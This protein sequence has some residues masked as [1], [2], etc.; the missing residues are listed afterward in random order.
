MLQTSGYLDVAKRSELPRVASEQR[1]SSPLETNIK[2]PHTG[3]ARPTLASVTLAPWSAEPPTTRADHSN[4]STAEKEAALSA[5][6]RRWDALEP[7]QVRTFTV[8]GRTGVYELQE[9]IFLMCEES[10]E[11]EKP[12]TV[13]LIP[14]PSVEDPD[15]E[16]PIL[17]SK[18][19]KVD[20]PIADLTMDPTQD[21]IVVSEYEPRPVRSMTPPPCN[22]YHLLSMSTG[23]PHPLAAVPFLDFPPASVPTLWPRQ[24]IQIMGD[25]LVALVSRN[26]F[27]RGISAGEE[28]MVAWNWKTGEVMGVS[29]AGLGGWS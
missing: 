20:F 6:E 12:R 21:L 11:T 23:E 9:G 8:L 26:G 28:E 5:R 7:A 24:L 14:L 19:I 16:D 15:L 18:A 3:R 27:M 29:V 10:S 17:D 22:R 4:L 25:T 1:P 13:R 2:S